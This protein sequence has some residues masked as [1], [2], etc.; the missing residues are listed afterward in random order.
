MFHILH[1]H[2]EQQHRNTYLSARG[3]GRKTSKR[4]LQEINI[5]T[6]RDHTT[7]R[8]MSHCFLQVKVCICSRSYD[9]PCHQDGVTHTPRKLINVS[10]TFNYTHRLIKRICIMCCF[11]AYVHTTFHMPTTS[12]SLITIKTKLTRGFLYSCYI[13]LNSTQISSYQKLH[14]FQGLL[15][16]HTTNE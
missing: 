12:G 10:R 2:F 6:Y 13:I 1:F 7:V 16:Y 15:L 14:N 4:N 11:M 9:D 8:I 3:K 5:R